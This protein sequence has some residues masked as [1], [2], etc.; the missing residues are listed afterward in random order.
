MRVSS[1]PRPNTQYQ[2]RVRTPESWDCNSV[3]HSYPLFECKTLRMSGKW[4]PA[5]R[6]LNAVSVAARLLRSP[7]ICAAQPAA[8]PL[9]SPSPFELVSPH[10]SPHSAAQHSTARALEERRGEE[11]RIKAVAL[12]TR[13]CPQ[14]SP[15]CIFVVSVVGVGVAN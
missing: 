9:L 2:E 14:I 1:R 12:C 7:F 10:A 15:K 11:R 3:L 4:E 13:I 6:C 5:R 8:E